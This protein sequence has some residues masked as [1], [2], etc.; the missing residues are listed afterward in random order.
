MSQ[1][2]AV[3][4]MMSNYFHD[5]A[6]A[7]IMACSVTMLLVLGR[8]DRTAEPGAGTIIHRLYRGISK[9][10]I[11]SWLWVLSAG[12]LRVMTFNE[13]EWPNAVIK[14]QEYALMVKY[15]LGLAM[16]G[17]GAF[18]WT[19]VRKKMRAAAAAQPEGPHVL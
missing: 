4:I 5:V 8:Y 9:V 2:V 10:V 6:S 1:S 14:H 13:Y 7:M 15:C 17:G 16:L 11:F 12:L 18:M 19:I 3:F